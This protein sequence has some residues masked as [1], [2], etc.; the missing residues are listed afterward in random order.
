MSIQ[1]T[2]FCHIFVFYVLAFRLIL[3]ISEQTTRNRECRSRGADTMIIIWT[4]SLL[5]AL[6]AWAGLDYKFGR[7]SSLKKKAARQ[8]K[9][10]SSTLDTFTSGDELFRDFFAEI[11]RA[12][13]HI[14]ILFYIIKDDTFSRNFLDLLI[15]KAKE[16]V[17][18]KLMADW[19]GSHKIPGSWIKELENCG[20]EFTFSHKPKFPFLFYSFQERNHRKIAIIDGR[21]GYLGGFNIGKEYVGQDKKL[22]PWRDYHLKITGEGALDLQSEFLTD[23]Y[24]ATG[25]NFF[26]SEQFFPELPDEGGS[27]I[28][29]KP[30]DGLGLEK[31]FSN[32]IKSSSEQIIIGTPYF[33]PGTVLFS[34]LRA[35]LKRNVR[36]VIIVP[37]TSDHPFVKEAAFRYFRILQ[38]EGAEILQYRNGFY[39]SKVMMVDDQICD[40]G[41]ANFDKRSLFLNYEINC[42]IYDPDYIGTVMRELETDIAN[43]RPFPPDLLQKPGLFASLKEKIAFTLSPFL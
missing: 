35:A 31:I 33:I 39:H 12:E 15:K 43:S 13:Q 6:L 5:L 2:F 3:P 38:K 19:I 37:E 1:S 27:L 25:V 8:Y 29:I 4:G 32:L 42:L 40:I 41:T 11:N 30:T 34:E 14:H 28:R 18:V 7:A 22:S 17:S 16:G 9:F 24:T 26:G 36:L 21:I 10:R 23:W 20:A